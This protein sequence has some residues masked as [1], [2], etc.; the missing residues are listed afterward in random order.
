MGLG[1]SAS[2][3]RSLFSGFGFG[4]FCFALEIVIFK[5]RTVFEFWGLGRRMERTAVEK[6]KK[7]NEAGTNGSREVKNQIKMKKKKKSKIVYIK[8]IKLKIK[9]KR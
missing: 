9:K 6:R 8:K 7:G 1:F 5:G 3:P 2:I 4:L